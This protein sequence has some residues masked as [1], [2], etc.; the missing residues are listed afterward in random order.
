MITFLLLPNMS[1]SD[2]ESKFA[3]RK[4]LLAGLEMS[5]SMLSG[6]GLDD[7]DLF[8]RPGQ[9]RHL[10][11]HSNHGVESQQLDQRSS[12][13]FVLSCLRGFVSANS[14]AR[15][16]RSKCEATDSFLDHRSSTATRRPQSPVLGIECIGRRTGGTHGSRR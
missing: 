4:I 14:T 2:I 15:H 5:T 9:H 1:Y 10:G 8:L 12:D 11:C 7:V 6:L 16:Q 3:R 13:T